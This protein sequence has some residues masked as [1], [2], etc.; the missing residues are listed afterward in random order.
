MDL[1]KFGIRALVTV[2]FGP[3]ILLASWKGGYLFLALI[4]SLVVLGIFEFYNLAAQKVTNP[5]KVLGMLSGLATCFVLFFYG[6]QYLWVVFAAAF[7]VLMIVELFRNAAGA[8]LNV[9]TTIMGVMYV[10][11]FFGFLILIREFPMGRDGPFDYR[12]GGNLVM[13]IFIAIWVCDTA[14]YMLGSQFG[15]HKL[16]E[17][18]SP[19]KTMEGAV[20][21]FLFA[22]LTAYLCHATFLNDFKLVDLLVIGGICGTLGQISDLVESLF[23]RDAGAKDSSNLIPGHGGVLDRFDSEML[24]A[25]AIY[26]YLRFLVS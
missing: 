9:A 11:F 20:F 14:A 26:F 8:I 23:K 13:F 7:V 24:V 19:N 15:R 17:R 5:Q 6:V 2:V 12:S 18:V 22:L 25:P 10:A 4:A 3:F 21:G 1:N 16:F